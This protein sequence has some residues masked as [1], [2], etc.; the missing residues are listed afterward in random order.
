MLMAYEDITILLDLHVDLTGAVNAEPGEPIVR[1]WS[2]T[3]TVR[4]AGASPSGGSFH[5]NV[6]TDTVTSSV[7]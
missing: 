7:F 2:A 4:D 6:D 1:I 5:W 3:I